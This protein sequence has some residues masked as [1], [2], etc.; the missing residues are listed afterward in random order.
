VKPTTDSVGKSNLKIKKLIAI[1]L[2]FMRNIAARFALVGVADTR[3]D[4]EATEFVFFGRRHSPGKLWPAYARARRTTLLL[5]GIFVVGAALFLF[6]D[7]GR[8][9]LVMWD[10]SRVGVSALEMS[11]RGLSIVTTY[12][13]IPDLWNTKPPLVIWLMALALRVIPHPEFAL[14]SP[15]ALAA[16]GTVILT[17]GFAWRVTRSPFAALLAGVLL[18]ASRGF[19][20]TH[21]ARTGD[22]DSL[23]VFFTTAYLWLFF[24]LLHRVRVRVMP[25]VLMGLS[26]AAAVLTKGIAGLVPGIGVAVYLTL[27][28]RWSRILT[29]PT[30]LVCAFVAAAPIVAFYVAREA[31]A[32]GFL[33]AMWA[34]EVMRYFVDLDP[35]STASRSGTLFFAN[36]IVRERSFSLGPLLALVPLG[37]FYAK[38]RL[39]LGITYAV[40]VATSFLVVVSLSSTRYSWYAASAYPWLAAA[41]SIVIHAGIGAVRERRLPLPICLSRWLLPC[42]TLGMIVLL[43]HATVV[44]HLRGTDWRDASESSYGALFERLLRDDFRS[45]TIVDPGRGDAGP[46][47][48]GHYNPILRFYALLHETRS[49]A[50]IR[51]IHDLS[52]DLRSAKVIASCSPE[53]NLNLLNGAQQFLRVKNCRA[54]LR[55]TTRDRVAPTARTAEIVAKP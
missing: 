49:G 7:L 34:N 50:S 51:V 52:E 12:D 43:A 25:A 42:I 47:M 48:H 3:V 46:I 40:V 26:V 31:M 15:S 9:P 14:R 1:L 55:D 23:L 22:Y 37:W 18:I 33:Q 45:V 24:I 13:F 21:V 16:L 29:T 32:P 53:V 41:A 54:V 10:E 39:R 28:G 6:A 44:R 30:Y 11:L 36:Y 4:L 17:S 27:S 20:G 35:S 19:F 38:P 2:A 8:F 5:A